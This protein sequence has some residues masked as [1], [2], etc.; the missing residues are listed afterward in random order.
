[1]AGYQ[2]LKI[3]GY[4][5]GLVQEREEFLLPDDA[6][7]SLRNAYVWRERIKRKKGCLLLGRL[8]RNLVIQSLG[9]TIASGVQF[10]LFTQINLSGTITG[11]TQANPGEVTTGANHLLQTNQY[12]TL[13]AVGGM[14]QVNGK[15]YK[16]TV[17]AA[18]KFTIGVDTSTYTAYAAGGTWET[19]DLTGEPLKAIVPGS[20]VIT[21]P[22]G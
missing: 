9:N 14:T 11:I 5:T 7:P 10:N 2:P 3:T 19:N 6:Y 18:N 12:V 20:V 17:T 1:M 21:M 13:D 4:S 22:D 16:I 8:Q 15:T